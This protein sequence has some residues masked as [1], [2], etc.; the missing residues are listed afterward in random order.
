MKI[1]SEIG[2]AFLWTC[3]LTVTCC[4]GNPE[5]NQPTKEVVVYNDKGDSIY[6][7]TARFISHDL[8]FQV[9]KTSKYWTEDTVRVI[10]NK[11]ANHRPGFKQN[12]NE[13]FAD[14]GV[15]YSFPLFNTTNILLNSCSNLVFHP[16]IGKYLELNNGEGYFEI[17]EGSTE[18]RVN[19][20]IKVI[21]QH[22]SK[23]N[24]TAYIDSGRKNM[25]AIALLTGRAFITAG[26]LKTTL[27]KSGRKAVFNP[28]NKTLIQVKCELDDELAW[29][30]D[31]FSYD[32]I[33]L[34]DLFQRICRWY[35]LELEY[36]SNLPS[37]HWAFGGEFKESAQVIVER[38]NNT[39]MD[40]HCRIERRK[41]IVSKR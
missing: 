16:A 14:R 15:K 27:N 8:E 33:E 11:V 21:G 4:A 36:P 3:I 38:L 5:K 40:F 25:I 34:H 41:L 28:A 20:Q 26:K 22:G 6:K 24:I 18:I 2:R 37:D 29:T 13:I 10:R 30:K 7:S 31:E 17:N 35:D 23:L 39:A 1:K 9:Q 19:D 12:F 32:D